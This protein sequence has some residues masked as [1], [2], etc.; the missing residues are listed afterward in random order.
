MIA[1]GLERALLAQGAVVVSRRTLRKVVRRHARVPGL[2]FD[3]PHATSYRVPRA[4]LDRIEGLPRDLPEHVV[5]VARELLEEAGDAPLAAWRALFHEAVHRVVDARFVGRPAALKARIHRIGQTEFDEVRFVLR[6]DDRLVA[7]DDD[8]ATYAE[9]AAVWAEL[10]AFAPDLLA[11]T[12]PALGDVANVEATLAIDSEKLLAETRVDGAPT[13]EE[14]RARGEIADPRDK[15]AVGEVR[16]WRGGAPRESPADAPPMSSDGVRMLGRVE[17]MLVKARRSGIESVPGEMRA[18][19]ERL[20]AALR[21]RGDLDG[22]WTE[23]LTPVVAAAA[24]ARRPFNVDARTLYD[25]ERACVAAEEDLFTVDV[26]GWVRHLG[27]R[28]IRRALPH[29]RDVHVVK[30]LR[31]AL[32]RAPRS[33]VPEPARARFAHLVRDCVERAELNLRAALRPPM[34][35]AFADVGLTVS[36]TPDVVALK[37]L[38]E[39]LIDLAVERGQLSLGL[40]RDAFSRNA[41]KLD[42][43]HGP[44]ELL[45]GDPLLRAD[46]RL[47]TVLDGVYRRGEIYLRL[48]ARMSELL[49]ATRFGRFLT[50]FVILPFGGAYVGLEGVQHVVGPLAELLFHERIHHILRPE[51]FVVTA[52]VLFALIHSAG[53]RMAALGVARGFGFVL[54][55]IFVAAPRWVARQAVVRAIFGS[56]LVGFAWRYLVLPLVPLAVAWLVFPRT[57]PSTTVGVAEGAAVLVVSNV[58]LN[59]REGMRARAALGEWL[60]VQV[61]DLTHRVLPGLF[62]LLSHF[63]GALVEN[64]ERGIYAVDT[65]LRY[66][67]G[68]GAW[69][70]AFKAVVGSAWAFVSYILRIY[71][72]VLIEPQLNPLKH[73]PV[74]TVAAKLIIPFAPRLI[75]ASVHTLEKVM[76]K[77]AAEIIGVPPIVLSPGFFGFLVWEFKENFKLYRQNQRPMLAPVIIGHHGESMAALLKPGL[78]SGTIPKTYAK[79]RRA[80]FKGGRSAL[81]HREALHHIE[82]AI[83]RF[84]ERDFVELLAVSPLFGIRAEVGRIEIASNR[85]RIEIACP[86]LSS[87]SA[88]LAFEEQSGWLLASVAHAG[89]IDALDATKRIVVENALAGL[90]ARA[91]VD[92]VRE[93][94][95]ARIGEPAP[96]DV[97]DQGLVVWPGGDYEKQTIEPL[98]ADRS[99]VTRAAWN[100]AWVVGGGEV[101]RIV[102]GASLLPRSARPVTRDRPLPEARE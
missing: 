102:E 82:E 56:R 52:I 101:K 96:Y 44:R 67:G 97:A 92:L 95:E 41:L 90:Y 70:V 99:G 34:E 85:V 73:F 58:A 88:M 63:F 20:A 36:S 62:G 1:P 72:N 14:L 98:V 66:R 59:S 38:I 46:D 5:L 61:R 25:I 16:R 17:P 64:V 57:R 78:H 47:S 94:L 93:R 51:S 10:R 42:N 33:S 29:L 13:T 28:P 45:T 6:H 89:W 79:L 30:S 54:H 65:W 81:A 32:A 86:A 21:W 69:S 31:S 53:A 49:F 23:T 26:P 18:F 35:A 87:A 22:E 50:L 7:P 91:A 40:L 3:V 76:P 2:G 74:V 48:L 100:A 39:E 19:V 80:S 43:L 60:A 68:A 77:R 8:A 9:L 83:R 12:F 84:V 75:G 11:R 71:V 4:A 24:H 15:D 27:A 37:K 55:A